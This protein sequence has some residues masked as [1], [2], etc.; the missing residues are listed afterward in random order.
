M[1]QDDLGRR[2][3]GRFFMAGAVLSCLAW[4]MSGGFAVVCNGQ[5]QPPCF[6]GL[7]GVLGGFS[8]SCAGFA[9]RDWPV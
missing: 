9:S 5:C 1:W 7:T 3:S 4:N 2:V 6:S 8:F